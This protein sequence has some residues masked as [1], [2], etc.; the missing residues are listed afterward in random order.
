MKDIKWLNALWWGLWTFLTL[1]LLQNIKRYLFP[2]STFDMNE[3]MEGFITALVI[4]FVIT[5]ILG[6]DR[7]E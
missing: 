3:F 1:A 4:C 6:K 2:H 5:Y 7:C